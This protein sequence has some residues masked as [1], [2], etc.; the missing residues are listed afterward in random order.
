MQLCCKST[1]PLV[2]LQKKAEEMIRHRGERITPGRIH[3]LA[4]LLSERRAVTHHEIEERLKGEHRFDRVT[5]Y[6][7]LEWLNEKGFVHRLV[8]ADRAW[9]FRDNIHEYSLPH[10]HFECLR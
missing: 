1:N 3:I 2:N 6:R 7:V 5:L 4:M 9:R 8:S 10:A